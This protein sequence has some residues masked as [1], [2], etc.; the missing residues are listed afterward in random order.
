MSINRNLRLVDISK[1]LES[2]TKKER[3]IMEIHDIHKEQKEVV[4]LLHPMLA[5]AQMM[6]E[7]LA[8]LM[9]TN[10]R[11]LIPDF[12]GHGEAANSDYESAVK[13]AAQLSSYLKDQNIHEVQLAFGA[14]MGAVV[15]MELLH[16]SDL[17][18]YHLFFEGASM[19]TNASFLNF[20]MKRIM[21]AKH[22]KAQANPEIAVQKM[23]ELY[24]EKVKHVM[25][26]Q[27][28][29]IS[30]TSLVNVVHDC[31]YVDLPTLTPEQQKNTVFAYG[32]KDADLKLA[33]K[34]CAKQ[35]PQAKL[36]VWPGRGHCTYITEAPVQYAAM[37]KALINGT[38]T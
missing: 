8:D 9:G 4:L 22:R 10:Y 13:E 24:G 33:R 1:F 16:D 30:E 34:V 15:L 26:K 27:M 19:Y 36:M 32:E 14:S 38:E 11:Y 25:A 29:E 17:K 5:N 23:A 12:S 31:A 7:L 20:M 2:M 28:V 37:L 3:K 18:F 6:Q 35:Y 21:V